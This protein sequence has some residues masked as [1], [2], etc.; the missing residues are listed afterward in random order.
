MIIEN[1]VQKV[2]TFNKGIFNLVS[3]NPVEKYI[4]RLKKGDVIQSRLKVMESRIPIFLTFPTGW[5]YAKD[6]KDLRIKNLDLI[7]QAMIEGQ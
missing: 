6:F 7:R 5:F 3:E 1:N 2:I 4:D